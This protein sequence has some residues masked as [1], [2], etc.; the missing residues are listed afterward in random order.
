MRDSSPGEARHSPLIRGVL[1]TLL[2]LLGLWISLAFLPALAWATIIA[3]AIDPLVQ[4]ARR[5]SSDRHATLIAAAFACALAALILVPLVLGATQAAREAKDLANWIMTIRQH[6]IPPPAWLN[7]LPIGS[8]EITQWW[9]ADLANPHGA[10]QHLSALSRTGWLTQ[11]RLIGIGLLHRSVVFAFTLLTLFFLIRDRDAIIHHAR[12]VIRHLLG[13]TGDRI[14]QQAILSVRGTIDGLVLVGLGEGAV[15]SIVYL[16]LGVPH[17]FLLG[18]VT[19]IAAMIPFGAV[20]VFAIAVLMLLAQGSAGGAIAVMVIGLG[21]VFIADHL[22]RPGLIGSATKLPFLWVLIGILG[23]VETLGLIG[24][25]VGPATMAV[26][27]MLWRDYMSAITPGLHSN[28]ASGP[29]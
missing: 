21:V 8:S 6:G 29:T 5:A 27:I 28:S 24:L 11:T 9:R 3:I 10:N 23:G 2:A 17:P 22:I 7:S 19:A 16:V 15:M 1:V 14:A 4:K 25:F 18:A 12:L 26:L 20:L 13:H